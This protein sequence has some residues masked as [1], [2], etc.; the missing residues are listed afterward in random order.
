MGLLRK[1]AGGLWNFCRIAEI[2]N[3]LDANCLYNVQ[4][5]KESAVCRLQLEKAKNT[6]L[7]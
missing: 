5:E 3:R 1:V 4:F 2:E 6:L 7:S